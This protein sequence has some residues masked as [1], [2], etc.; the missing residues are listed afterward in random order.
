METLPDG[1]SV[2]RDDAAAAAEAQSFVRHELRSPL[3]VIQPVLGM[4]LDGTAGPLDDK[5]LGYLRMLERSVA[6]LTGM[7]ASVV[8]T[9]WLEVAA[10]PAR[11][12]AIDVGE[13]LRGTA[14][15]V[16]SSL[17]V[18]P[19]VAVHAAD[20]LPALRG[21]RYRLGRALR[22]VLLN[23]C[24]CTPPE[25]RVDLRAEPGSRPGCLAVVCEDTGCG[26]P[27]DDL[28]RVF[29]LGFRGE[30]A[31]ASATYGLGLGLSVARAIVEEHG[32][33][34]WL[35]SSVGEGTRVS[36]DLPAASA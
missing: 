16:R 14:A 27:P 19:R 12:E 30:A 6:R 21:D 25:G 18:A 13:L 5:Q 9:G 31:R 2:S 29:D 34:I 28:A 8:E 17:E 22:N 20:G 11:P 35:E 32:G 33:S 23:A 7:I 3:A 10:M 26:V 24:T 4:L 36:M 15:D 1:A